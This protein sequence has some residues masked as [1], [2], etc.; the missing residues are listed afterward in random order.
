MAVAVSRTTHG[1]GHDSNQVD[2]RQNRD[3]IQAPRGK[4]A[5]ANA[6]MRTFEY[7]EPL[8]ICIRMQIAVM[9]CFIHVGYRVKH[10]QWKTAGSGTSV[11][12][13]AR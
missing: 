12:V 8:E 13:D 9:A 5:H 4:C 1:A 10:L 11:V 6:M 3:I 7:K 2:N